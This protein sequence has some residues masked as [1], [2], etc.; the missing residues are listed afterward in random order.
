MPNLDLS[1]TITAIIAICALVSPIATTLINNHHQKSMKKLEYQEQEKQRKIERKREIYEDYVRAAGA[2]IQHANP[3]AL[4]EFG[5]HSA[6]I[7]CYVPD[8]LI[9]DIQQLEK[10]VFDGNRRPS[11][12]QL[13]VVVVKL[14]PL[15]QEL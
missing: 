6:Q 10:L 8:D 5:R 4:L 2:C 11:Q 14:R 9:D 7:L 13:D 12:Q 15:L 1:F 3:E